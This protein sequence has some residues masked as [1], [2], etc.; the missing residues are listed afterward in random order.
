MICVFAFQ[1]SDDLFPIELTYRKYDLKDQ[2]SL[3]KGLGK[4]VIERAPGPLMLLGVHLCGTLSIRAVQVF[5]DFPKCVFLALK[6]CCLPHPAL[7]DRGVAWRLGQHT[8]MAKDVVGAGRYKKG[9]WVGKNKSLLAPIFRTWVCELGNAVDLK[10]AA[11]AVPGGTMVEREEVKGLQIPEEGSMHPPSIDEPKGTKELTGPSI[12]KKIVN[13]KL[14]HGF[15]VEKKSQ[16]DQDVC[17]STRVERVEG[18]EPDG[19]KGKGKGNRKDFYQTL[20][21]FAWRE[22]RN[23]DGELR[24]ALALPTLHFNFV[25]ALLLV[26]FLLLHLF[27]CV[28]V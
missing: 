16:S 14:K 12:H 17:C 25:G 9:K 26:L 8:I 27:L 21:V 22:F 2:S 18:A 11:Q 15:L 7:G 10:N 5:N 24:S 6:P 1:R 23:I 20:F 3:R 28:I 19:A 4:H 13:L